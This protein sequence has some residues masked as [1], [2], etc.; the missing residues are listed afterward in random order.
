MCRVDED[1]R[2]GLLQKLMCDWLGLR[3]RL[4]LIEHRV[5]HGSVT[6]AFVISPRI[7][8]PLAA[9]TAGRVQKRSPFAALYLVIVPPFAA[10]ASSGI[11][12]QLHA[13]LSR[14]DPRLF[15]VLHEIRPLPYRR[16]LS[17]AGRR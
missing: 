16:T 14:Q 7:A 11:A 9:T 13:I 10:G 6:A 3:S 1:E 8:R 12:A 5:S 4:N 2:R 15:W 17:P